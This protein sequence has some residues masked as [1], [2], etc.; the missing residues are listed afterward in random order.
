ME[1]E[2][3]WT[4][5]TVNISLSPGKQQ[6]ISKCCKREVNIVQLISAHLLP[7]LLQSC[8]TAQS[9]NRQNPLGWQPW[10]NTG[11]RSCELV[12][13]GLRGPVVPIMGWHRGFS[14]PPCSHACSPWH[15]SSPH[16]LWWASAEQMFRLCTSQATLRASRDLPR[17]S[18]QPRPSRRWGGQPGSWA[19]PTVPWDVGVLAT[20]SYSWS[21][22]AT[23]LREIQTNAVTQIFSVS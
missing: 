6:E 23:P 15:M 8:I 7:S 21:T 10:D 2:C 1:Q 19:I 16:H 5:V 20:L 11:A 3:N 4:K 12:Q 14:S 13:P 17:S 22:P 18:P 9:S